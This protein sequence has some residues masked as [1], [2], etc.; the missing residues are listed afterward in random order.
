MG[1]LILGEMS[2]RWCGNCD[3][4]IV[5]Q[6]K[7]SICHCDTFSVTHTPP[8]DVRPAFSNDIDRIKEVI[9]SQFGP[10]SADKLIGK[11]SLVILNSVPSLDRMDEVILHGRVLGNI[12]YKLLTGR[13]FFIAQDY[14]ISLLGKTPTSN[15]IIVDD[16]AIPFIEKGASCLVP[17]ITEVIGEFVVDDE[18]LVCDKHGVILMSGAAQMTSEEMIREKRGVAVKSRRRFYGKEYSNFLPEIEPSWE[19]AVEANAEMLRAKVNRAGKFIREVIESNDLPMAVSYS[20]GK[21]SLATLLLVL[22]AGYKPDLL[23]INTGLELP[24]TIENVHEVAERYSLEI[25]TFDAGDAFYR[26][27]EYFGPPAKDFRW[28]CKICKL[29]PATRLISEKYP[30]GLLSFIGQRQYESLQRKKKGDKWI[31][32]W[33]PNQKGFSP[34]Q[35]WN[36]LTVWLYIFREKGPYNPWYERGPGRIGC[37]L[38]P[39]SSVADL[40]RIRDGYEGSHTFFEYLEKW[41]KDKGFSSK[42]VELG[43]W[44]WRKY[45]GSVRQLLK[46]RESISSELFPDAADDH[47]LT[48]RDEVLTVKPFRRENSDGLD[49]IVEGRF[50][51]KISLVEVGRLAPILGKIITCNDEKLMIEDKYGGIINIYESFFTVEGEESG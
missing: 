39:A 10:A 49:W 28:C 50:N 23:F 48:K 15:V 37:W 8:G 46:G 5:G 40:K 35:K 30:K 42:W 25:V 6:R 18:V 34:I 21:D 14:G 44:R 20:G 13:Y 9:L 29:G 22:E 43:L 51:R 33:V 27:L 24:E 45:P 17:G 2:L 16:G 19:R 12:K 11:R 36:A 1:R 47:L 41:A 3:L 4:P 32:P 26:A 31:N 38:C 7:C